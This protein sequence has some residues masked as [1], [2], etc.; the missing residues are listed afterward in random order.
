MTSSSTSS[1]SEQ[2]GF[3]RAFAQ[4]WELT[5]EA[6]LLVPFKDVITGRI[7]T[8]QEYPFPYIAIIPG[9]GSQRWR[10][11]RGEGLQRGVSV[12]IWVD[13]AKLDLGET[14]AE[15]ARRVWANRGWCYNFGQVTDCLDG[16]PPKPTQ[17]NQPTFQCWE[18]VKNFTL[19]IQEPRMDGDCNPPC[20][21]SVERSSS[22]I[23]SSSEYVPELART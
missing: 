15:M 10:S 9:G 21:C 16:G 5:P 23:S 2:P 14:I 19:C 20:G 4:R 7:P 1:V 3:W 12:H 22:S 13:P 6:V 8:T 17:L 18:L 11:D